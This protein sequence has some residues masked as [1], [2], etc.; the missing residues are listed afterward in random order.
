[1][2]VIDRFM[3]KVEKTDSCWMWLGYTDGKMGYGMFWQD[4]TMRLSHRVAH[5]LFKG[6]IGNLHVCHSCDVPAC[7][8]PNH[9]WLGTNAQNIADKV[10][11][12]RASSM[13]GEKSPNAKLNSDLVRWIR[14]S[15]LTGAAIGR[16]LGVDRSTVNYI[17]HRKL[18]GHIL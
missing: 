7:V 4:G 5:T 2:N 13:Q 15:A 11:K 9:L 1:M 3:A 6:E 12:G 17:R 18:W 10:S 14:T 16:M 8:N